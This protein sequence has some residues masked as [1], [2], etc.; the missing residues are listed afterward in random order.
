MHFFCA[1]I[2]LARQI[3]KSLTQRQHSGFENN[4]HRFFRPGILVF[5]TLAE[6]RYDV[7][8]VVDAEAEPPRNAIKDAKQNQRDDRCPQHRAQHMRSARRAGYRAQR[9]IL[10]LV[11]RPQAERQDGE[12][13]HP[14]C[15]EEQGE[16]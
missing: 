11:L 10:I 12:Q 1:I 9:H 16:K 13:H 5:G 8:D 4:R 7:R 15:D 2:W 6:I 14:P 3:A